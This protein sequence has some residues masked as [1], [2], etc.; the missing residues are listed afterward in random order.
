MGGAGG[1]ARGGEIATECRLTNSQIKTWEFA[2]DPVVRTVCSC[3][4]GRRFS[5]WLGN[6]KLPD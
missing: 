6:C 2:G 3:H 4:Q 1:G 5:P